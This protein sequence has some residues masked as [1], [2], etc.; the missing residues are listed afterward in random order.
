[1]AVGVRITSDN[2]N[3]KTAQVT[4]TPT[5][6]SLQNLG[7]KTIPFNNIT[8]SPYGTY[9]LYF[10]EYDYTYTLEIL[11]P[12]TNSELF[13]FVSRMVG[14]DN[15]GAVT[16]NATDF[17]AEIINFN[18]DSTYYGINN[19]YPSTELGFLYEF[20]GRD[21]YQEKY[22]IFTDNNNNV[23]GTYTGSINDRDLSTLE[24]RWLTYED[25]TNGVFKAS[26]GTN[27][28]TMEWNPEVYGVNIEWDY[29]AT[30][31]SGSFVLE[32]SRNDNSGSVYIL[33]KQDG[34]MDEIY[35][36][37]E[38][39]IYTDFKLHF[40]STFMINVTWDDAN[41]QYVEFDIRDAD[42]TIIGDSYLLANN[43]IV[44][45]SYNYGFFG[46]NKAFL[47]FWNQNDNSVDYKIYVYNGDTDTMITDTHIRGVNFTQFDTQSNNWFWP[48]EDRSENLVLT[49]YNSIEWNN[50]GYTVD[51]CDIWYLLEGDTEFSKYTFA[52]DVIKTI[53]PWGP[54]TDDG[55]FT[56]V[57]DE[58]GNTKVLAINQNGLTLSNTLVSTVT[59]NNTNWDQIGNRFLLWLW[60][61]NSTLLIH[62]L[63][64]SSGVI[65]DTLEFENPTNHNVSTNRNIAYIRSN[66]QGYYINNN[67][68]TFTSTNYYPDTYWPY[69][70]IT[71]D[72]LDPDVIFLF[73]PS[74]RLGRILRGNSLGTE[75][76]LPES[77]NYNIRLGLD[78]IMY[79]YDPVGGSTTR[80]NLYNFSGTLL[81]TYDTDHEGWQNTE[82][83]KNRYITY[84]LNNGIYTIIMINEDDVL[85][86][87][88][89]DL[90]N[91]YSINDYA[92]WDD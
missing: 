28:Y 16:M 13:V 41:S 19:I 15:Y 84:C 20:E 64:N 72:F 2:L 27:V 71:S 38:P 78:K 62:Y 40:N 46:S 80:I 86:R 91:Y 6:G 58:N 31:R 85:V 57:A 92:W 1:M 83:S 10:A 8:T 30:N 37:S 17:T 4:F 33:C 36:I 73:N 43:D 56:I 55:Y 26:N 44:Y 81:N 54:I 69:T 79:V 90:N 65:L 53:Q 48:D 22:V 34:T 25:V 75:F 59:V 9:S 63:V 24:G 89:T 47:V 12:S 50:I 45:N 21:N 70:F 66:D 77:N 76:E 68:T 23:I 7:T 87:T 29:D 11:E 18:V 3:G 74:N 61:N 42:G 52:D 32:K 35:T 49:F 14:S 82:V 88:I 5:S 60:V 39:G 67:T 51:Y